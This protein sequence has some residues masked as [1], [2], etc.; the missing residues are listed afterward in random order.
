MTVENTMYMF[1]VTDEEADE[2][3]ELVYRMKQKYGERYKD[4]IAFLY[5]LTEPEA[6]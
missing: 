2:V 1:D 6:K 5:Q 3:I 4:M